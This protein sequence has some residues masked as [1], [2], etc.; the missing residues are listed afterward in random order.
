M[1]IN[2][3]LIISVVGLTVISIFNYILFFDPTSFKDELVFAVFIM[4]NL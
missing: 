4:F 2:K 3:K 1:G